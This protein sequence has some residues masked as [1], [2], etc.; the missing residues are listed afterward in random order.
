MSLRSAF[1][2]GSIAGMMVG[3]GLSV[4][5]LGNASPAPHPASGWTMPYVFA[6]SI[7]D[8]PSY[9]TNL[10]GWVLA[11]AFGTAVLCCLVW[12]GLGVRDRFDGLR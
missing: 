10:Q 2:Y 12:A 6:P 8:S 7:S 9:I 11:A 4:L 1:L 5:V 3:K